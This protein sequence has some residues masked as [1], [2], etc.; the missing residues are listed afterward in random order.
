MSFGDATFRRVMYLNV[1]LNPVT[2]TTGLPMSQGCL[3][4]K[5][6]YLAHSDSRKTRLRAESLLVENGVQDRVLN[7]TLNHNI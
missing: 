7:K 1:P 5:Q 2:S 3:F 4:S 6:Y